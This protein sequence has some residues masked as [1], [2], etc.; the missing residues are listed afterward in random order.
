ML[1]ARGQRT[2]YPD[3]ART[4]LGALLRAY[5]QPVALVT[6]MPRSGR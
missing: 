6:E 4:P 1:F 5:W 2:D 3:R